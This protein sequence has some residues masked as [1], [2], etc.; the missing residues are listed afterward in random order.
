MSQ[1]WSRNT[2]AMHDWLSEPTYFEFGDLDMS[3]LAADFDTDPSIR[4]ERFRQAFN[5]YARVDRRNAALAT[6]AEPYSDFA[7]NH[8]NS[9]E[10]RHYGGQAHG[11]R[12]AEAEGFAT[13]LAGL[14]ES[15][16][17]RHRAHHYDGTVSMIDPR[18][19][20]DGGLL[21]RWSLDDAHSAN[22]VRGLIAGDPARLYVL[23]GGYKPNDLAQHL[24]DGDIPTR[25]NVGASAL[26]DPRC[27]TNR[28]TGVRPVSAVFALTSGPHII[29]YSICQPCYWEFFHSE[30]NQIEHDIFS[31]GIDS[32]ADWSDD[33]N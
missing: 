25:C 18:K 22:V 29:F 26:C 8:A 9:V 7:R 32:A 15:V 12:E 5:V 27:S 31:P 13:E 14:R 21:P 28:V 33:H 19:A 17:S 2:D 24:F 6:C 1:P 23:R 30:R 10:R 11:L 3:D 16:M 4:A 20:D